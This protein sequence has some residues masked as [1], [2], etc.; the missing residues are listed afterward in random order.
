MRKLIIALI[1]LIAI[2]VI[3]VVALPKLIDVNQYHDRIQAQL[4]KK[5]NR[6]VQLGPMSLNILPLQFR[7]ENAVIGEDPKFQS[8]RPFATAQEL[9][10]RAKLWPLLRKD[11]QVDSLQLLRPNIELIR[12][13]QGNWN[14]SSLA[15]PSAGASAASA[16]TAAKPSRP[17]APAAQEK[18]PGAS[19]EAFSLSSLEITDGQVA[20]TDLQKHQSRS[21][22]DHIDLMLSEYAPRRPFR[23]ALAA[24]LPGQGKQL[25]RVE[26]KAGPVQEGN[27]IAS[28]LD[29]TIKLDQVSLSGLKKF[30]NSEAL[31]QMEATASGDATLKNQ[32]GKLSSK[33]NLKIEQGRISGVDIG[34]PI[35]VDYDVSDNVATDEIHIAKCNLKLG[36]TPVSIAGD[37][38]THPTPAQ[39]DLSVK[40]AN[41]SITELARLAAAL[42]IAFNAGTQVAG[43]LS[44]DLR[45]RGAANQPQMSGALNAKDLVI[46]GKEL[47]QSVK[48]PAIDLQLSPDVIRSNQFTAQSAGTALLTSFTLSNY[49]KP[50]SVI[51]ATVK[52][53]NANLAEFLNI[54]KAYGVSALE[55]VTGSG[56]LSLDAR[57]AG[58][59]KNTSAL[60][61]S[62][63]GSLREA[64]LN[65][66]SLTKPLQVKNANLRFAQNSAVLE[67]LNASLG[68]T[69]A[70]GSV[71]VRNFDAPQVQFTLI[72][73]KVNVAEIRQITRTSPA[74][75]TAQ[76]HGFHI[77]PAA[78]AAVPVKSTGEPSL[79]AKMTGSG[80]VNV[81]VVQYDDLLLNN[82]RS[83]VTL[84]RGVIRLS[85]LTAELFGGQETGSITI[86]T[87]APNTTYQVNTKLE[88]V[89]SNKLLSATTSLKQILFGLLAGNANTSFISSP[90]TNIA[91]TLN[92]TVSFNLQNGRIANVDL[93]NQLAS[94]AKFTQ[95]TGQPP[96]NFS[97]VAQMTGDMVIKNGLA[98]TN[99]LKAAIDGGSLSAGGAINLVDESLNMRLTAVLNKDYSQKVGGTQVGGFMNTALANNRGEL[100]IPVIVTGTFAKPNFAPDVEKIAQ[101]KLNNILPT[102]GNPAAG[103]LGIMGKGGQPGSQKGVQGIMGVL[104]GKQ[105]DNTPEQAAPA[106]QPPS[107]QQ[108]QQTPQEQVFDLLNQLGK[109][110]ST[111]QPP[112]SP[113]PK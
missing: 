103:I 81:G 93:L 98:T 40:A 15:Q 108:Q 33:G 110:K 10:V 109:K 80:S 22:Y 66:P 45:A 18:E 105:Q 51:D 42:K 77:I 107:Q 4:S 5:L 100:V 91:Q 30:L 38:N 113:P 25:L 85:P 41:A 73:D 94:V 96:K 37:V 63:T 95:G 102:T 57:V 17:P 19:A 52:T 7:V 28:P 23:L 74:A 84:D 48:I 67:N 35:T 1:V 61:Y 97:N 34:Y 78:S 65:L 13:P 58:P 43:T 82:L 62:G 12:D 64:V 99:N 47:P 60:T 54:A 76:D 101:M 112:P 14:F 86:D 24:H 32:N 16:G 26:A 2:L 3:A 70:S 29:G 106:Q 92:G 46:S 21:V 87:R 104:G 72:A 90:G 88:R 49:T 11:V 44:A 75:K 27:L 59:L 39:M 36:P 9:N 111:Q 55:G 6:S 31:S 8:T 50:S 79:F 53:Q 20:V 71:M 56:A 68:S 83:N 89:D 69:N